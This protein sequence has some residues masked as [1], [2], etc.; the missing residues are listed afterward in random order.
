MIQIVTYIQERLHIN[1]DTGKNNEL[2]EEVLVL[3]SNET[4]TGIYDFSLFI[5]CLYDLSNRYNHPKVVV[6]YTGGFNERY[7]KITSG[8]NIPSLLKFSS[9]KHSGAMIGEFPYNNS[10]EPYLHDN[11]IIQKIKDIKNRSFSK[12]NEFCFESYAT[13]YL[14]VWYSK[15]NDYIQIELT[16]IDYKTLLSEEYFN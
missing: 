14:Y 13:R 5:H 4:N 12:S 16:N 6:H 10:D 8:Y 15:D 3:E 1:K 7:M 9:N 11:N 2:N